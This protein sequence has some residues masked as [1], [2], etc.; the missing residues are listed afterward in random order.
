LDHSTPGPITSGDAMSLVVVD[1]VSKEYRLGEQAVPALRNINMRI[2][3]GVFLAIAGP[4]G[5]GK[6]TLLNLIGCI[7]K[8]TAG[9]IV[10]DE[11]DV[12]E[13]TSD[14][15]ADVRARKIGFVFQT[16][17]LF[18]VLTAEENVEYPLL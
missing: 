13:L 3:Q 1:H 17:N 15:L 9:R 11:Q 6:S 10:I 4:S 2:E 12:S 5:S 7:D 14:Q 16:F 18:P 8:P